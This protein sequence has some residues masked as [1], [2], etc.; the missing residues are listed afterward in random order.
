M[1]SL[2][3]KAPTRTLRES[4]I[5]Y[6]TIW[7]WNLRISQI[8]ASECIPQQ[9]HHLLLPDSAEKLTLSPVAW[10]GLLSPLRP[11]KK[12]KIR[13]K[14]ILYFYAS[15]HVLRRRAWRRKGLGRILDNVVCRYRRLSSLFFLEM[16]SIMEE[17]IKVLKLYFWVE[18]IKKTDLVVRFSYFGLRILLEYWRRIVRTCVTV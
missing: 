1:R 5:R 2:P 8:L 4:E 12:F 14:N 6:F 9:E 11:L 17:S 13:P 18:L 7:V 15:W 10:R 3:D 16:V